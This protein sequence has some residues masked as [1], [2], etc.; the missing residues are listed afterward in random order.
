[1]GNRID[2]YASLVIDPGMDRYIAVG[3]GCCATSPDGITWTSR[4]IPAG[5][6]RSVTSAGGM[7]YHGD[8]ELPSELYP[9]RQETQRRARN[10]VAVAV[11][12]SAVAAFVA[13]VLFAIGA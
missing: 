8:I 9:Q 4:T 12:A 6:W 7:S 11:S 3:P 2:R 5:D 1:M 13:W 10:Y